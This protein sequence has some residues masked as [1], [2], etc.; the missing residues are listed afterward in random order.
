MQNRTGKAFSG[1]ENE[2]EKSVDNPKKKRY[3]F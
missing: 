3:F 1:V 2:N